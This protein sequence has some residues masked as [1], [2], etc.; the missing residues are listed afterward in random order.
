MTSPNLE[1]GNVWLTSFWG[2]S[3][4]N[5]GGVGFRDEGRRDTIIQQTKPGW[6]MVVYVT[7]KAGEDTPKALWG[8]VVGFYECSHEVATMGDLAAPFIYRRH[9]GRWAY[10]IKAD[11]AFTIL[12]EFRPSIRDFDPSLHTV[13]N[14]QAVSRHGKLLSDDVC[15]RLK[16]LPVQE[17]SVYGGDI[18]PTT[19]NI[20][21]PSSKGY[22]FGGNARGS[23]YFVPPE[24]DG[25]KELYILSLEGRSDHFLGRDNSELKDSKIVKV[26]LSLSPETR[27]DAFNKALPDGAFRW[28]I[29]RSTLLDGESRYSSFKVA[30][31][32]EMEMKK[33]LAVHGE[34]LGGEFYLAKSHSIDEAW[35]IGRN[36]AR[37]A[38]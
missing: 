8:K 24:S 20:F 4:E 22:V 2:W 6:I 9:E 15:E 25:E 35:R 10:A 27:Q 28:E 3:P 36:G 5:W 37:N 33:Y 32:G 12:P 11:R 18:S 23:G 26:G 14:P 34:W 16:Q 38:K 29:L 21:E 19:G 17:V 13:G 7:E 1:Y 31:R 30:E